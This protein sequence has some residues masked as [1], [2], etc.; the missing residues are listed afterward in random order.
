MNRPETPPPHKTPAPLPRRAFLARVAG[1]TAGAAFLAPEPPAEAQALSQTPPVPANPAAKD[2]SLPARKGRGKLPYQTRLQARVHVNQVGYHP[3]DPKR[4]VV[5]AN[6]PITVPAFVIVDDDV[7]PQVRFRGTLAHY[8]ESALAKNALLHYHADFD[9]FDRPGRYRLRLSDGR[10]SEPFSIGKEVY[11]RLMPLFSQ[12]F[13]TQTCG[14]Y[15]GAAHGPCHLDDGVAL[16]GPRDGQKLDASGGWHDAGDYL[17][18]VETTSY[19]TAVLLTGYSRHPEVFPHFD[20]AAGLPE[21]LARAKVGLDWLLKMHPA[22]DEFYYQVGDET[23]HDFWRLPEDDIPAKNPKWKPRSVLYG[24]GANLAGRTAAAFALASTLYRPYSR[25]FA[26]RCLKAAQSVYALGLKNKSI[27]STKPADFYPEL[28]W[29]DDMEWAAVRLFE[30]T[31]RQEYLTQALEFSLLA[32]SA[33]VETSVYNTHSMAHFA[34]YP[35]VAKKEQE[36]LLDYLHQD[37]QAV[38]RR[39]ANPYSL[40]TPYVWGTAEAA[41]GAAMVC[42]AYGLLAKD[43]EFLTL[44]NR[45]RDFVLGCNPFGLSCLIGG[46]TRYALYPH[47]QI[48]NLKEMELSG[49]IIGG[50]ALYGLYKGNE[51][52]L[53]N[54]EY[55]IPQRDLPTDPLELD[56][57]SVYQDN[58]ADYIANEPANDY[59]A[60]FLLVAAFDISTLNPKR[61]D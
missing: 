36:R 42:R 46:G 9:R 61:E 47:H 29:A 26:A 20:H 60:K 44:A 21:L 31:G 8:E 28:T 15:T 30:V 57:L 10:Q 12:Y 24:V 25:A 49:A 33:G 56:T 3:A 34:L 43:P 23:D 59:T 45:Q 17:K 11:T 48:A 1:L 39:A 18:F 41:A 32:G 38:R 27:L 37:A 2:P 19:V 13:D 16:G 35:H 55:A 52:A 14:A 4:A 53:D 50:P 54:L 22:P 51:I 40:G 58:V 5:S 6:R 7:T